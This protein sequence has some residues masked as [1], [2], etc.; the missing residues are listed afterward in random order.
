M[1]EQLLVEPTLDLPL[2]QDD[3]LHIPCDK[4]DLPDHEHE[5][6]EPHASAEFTNVIH[7]ASDTYDMKLLS[8]LNTLYYIEFDVLCNLSNLKEKLFMCA[9][10]PW[11]SRHTHH[12]I[13]KYNNK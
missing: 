6:T 2:S 1:T 5:S 8:S 12:V 9:D 7:V 13:G 10:L 3:L 11:L 4:D